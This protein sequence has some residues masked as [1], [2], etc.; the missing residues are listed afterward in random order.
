MASISKL[1]AALDTPVRPGHTQLASERQQRVH[2]RETQD[3]LQELSNM[4]EQRRYRFAGDTIEGIYTTVEHSGYVSAGQRKAI[5]NIRR[6]TG[7]A[8]I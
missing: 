7:D 3:F 2:Q 1:G 4:Q 6:G 8:P 5:N